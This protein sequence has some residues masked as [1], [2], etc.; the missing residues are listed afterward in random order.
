[1]FNL[2]LSEVQKAAY[3]IIKE[4]FRFIFTAIKNQKQLKSNYYS[5]MIPYFGVIVDGAE[6]WL[7][8]LK[9]SKKIELGVQLFDS[10]E[11]YHYEQ[12]R[13]SIKLWGNDYKSSYKLLEKSYNISDSYFREV[14]RYV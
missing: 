9:K 7:T 4:D 3:N 11:K 13:Q 6:D 10:T 14:E 2:E 5:M 8:R 1:M 12:L